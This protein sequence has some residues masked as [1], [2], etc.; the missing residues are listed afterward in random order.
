MKKILLKVYTAKNLGDDLFIKIILDRYSQTQFFLEAQSYYKNIFKEYS[1]LNIYDVRKRKNLMNKVRDLLLRNLLPSLYK[2]RIISDFFQ[3]H[4]SVF[5]IT[6]VFVCLGGSVFM[7]PKNLKYYSDVEVYTYLNSQY[8]DIKKFY[9]GGNFGPFKDEK[10]LDS[11]KSIFSNAADVCFREETSYNLFKEL[12]NV[13]YSSDIVFGLKTEPV[14]KIPNSIGFS[15]VG[16]IKYVREFDKETYINKYIELIELYQSKKY[17][18]R[19]FSF[20]EHEGDLQ[21]IKEIYNRLNE[22]SS[23]EIINYDGDIDDFLYKYKEVEGVYCGRFHAMILSMIFDQKIF[24]VIYS[25]KMTN[26]LRDINYKGEVIDLFK[27]DEIDTNYVYNQLQ[28]NKYNIQLEKE[29]SNKH[30]DELDKILL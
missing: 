20:A 13:R 14:E 8:P 4:E 2:K 5:K 18:I 22:R 27:F 16:P 21:I 28:D 1:N 29:L 23:I 15:I 24:P 7:Q 6:D 10:Y 11:Y 17:K 26:V 19:L 9:L 30:F 3:R 12:K 25:K